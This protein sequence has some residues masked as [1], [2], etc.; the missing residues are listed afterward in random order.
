MP[1]VLHGMVV[2]FIC[3]MS[4]IIIE[5][6]SFSYHQVQVGNDK[7]MCI[8]YAK[9]GESEREK[10]QRQ[11]EERTTAMR[12]NDSTYTAKYRSTQG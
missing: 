9:T 11:T 12:W 1:L 2:M 7:K 5:W 4:W 3:F 8:E 10:Q 6:F